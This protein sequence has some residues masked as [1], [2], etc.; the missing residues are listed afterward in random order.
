[1]AQRRQR[2]VQ[3]IHGTMRLARGAVY[4]RVYYWVL[5]NGRTEDIDPITAERVEVLQVREWLDGS[6]WWRSVM[7]AQVGRVCR[8]SIRYR[9]CLT[10]SQD[11]M[12]VYRG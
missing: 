1:M 2:V 3:R 9:T 4:G 5:D 10:S 7:S 11:L 12:S 8:E 6:R